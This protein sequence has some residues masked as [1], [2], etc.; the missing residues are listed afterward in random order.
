MSEENKQTSKGS[1][2]DER[3]RRRSEMKPHNLHL[4]S[5]K[6]FPS[7]GSHHAYSYNEFEDNYGNMPGSHEGLTREYAP[8]SDFES[9]QKP[10]RDTPMSQRG[11]G[12]PHYQRRD[13]WIIDEIYEK[14]YF[15]DEIDATDVSVWVENGVTV[16]SGTVP[17]E[18]MK[19]A[20]EALVKAI[21]GVRGV[22]NNIEIDCS[23]ADA[24]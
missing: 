3:R 13:E 16:L 4:W 15:S 7:E 23:K 24:S 14:L 8:E 11:K 1:P 21:F 18:I 9:F 22:S 19:E 12:A 2:R 10:D 5:E 6:E 17:E 20:T